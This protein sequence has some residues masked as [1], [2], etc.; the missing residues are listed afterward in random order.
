MYAVSDSWELEIPLGGTEYFGD[1][2]IVGLNPSTNQAS[3]TVSVRER[4][5]TTWS[6]ND[7][8]IECTQLEVDESKFMRFTCSGND[9]ATTLKITVSAAV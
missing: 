3:L 6:D 4:V 1:V 9:E 2:I 7:G 5:V 8:W